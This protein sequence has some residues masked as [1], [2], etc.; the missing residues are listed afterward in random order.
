MIYGCREIISHTQKQVCTQNF[1]LNQR[2]EFFHNDIIFVTSDDF[3]ER[4][5]GINKKFHKYSE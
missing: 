5:I 1:Q 4:E 3:E 2:Q